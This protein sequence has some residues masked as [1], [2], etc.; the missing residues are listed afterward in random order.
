MIFEDH[1]HLSSQWLLK[2]EEEVKTPDE[3]SAANRLPIY[4]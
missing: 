3:I 4:K 1:G 2:V